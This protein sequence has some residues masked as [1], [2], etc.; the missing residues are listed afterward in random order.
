M[1][2]LLL[3][4]KF[5]KEVDGGGLLKTKKLIEFMSS[6]HNIKVLSLDLDVKSVTTEGFNIKIPLSKKK[7][8]P[9]FFNLLKSYL[10]K[11]PLSIYRNSA[12]IDPCLL[13]ELYSWCDFVVI[14]HYLMC[15]YVNFDLDKKIILHEHNAEYIIWKRFSRIEKNPLKKFF[16]FLEY[17]R[18]KKYERTVCNKSSVIYSAPND[19][20]NL[21]SIGVSKP[22]KKTYHLGDDSLLDKVVVNFEQAENNVAFLGNLQWG[23]NKDGV[24]WF[25]RKVLPKVRK[26]VSDIKVH[27]IGKVDTSFVKQFNG[28]NVFFHGFVN[29]LSSMLSNVSVMISPLQYGSGMKVKNITSLYCGIPIVTTSIGS[30]GIDVVHGHSAFIADSPDEFS[31]Y[32]IMLLKNKNTCKEIGSNGK[33]IAIEKYSWDANMKEFMEEFHD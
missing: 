9:S 6:K 25:I 22:I 23:P 24:E 30:E 20:I 33:R 18:V 10:S 29:D 16:L 4:P 7:Y 1:N 27:I 17:I 31:E 28:V 19:A 32:L 15:Q 26:E 8:N 12:Y 14:D 2:I 5:P 21:K 11:T 3:T 13:S